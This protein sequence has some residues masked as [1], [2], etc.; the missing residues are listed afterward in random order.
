MKKQ[1][2]SFGLM[3]LS[4]VAMA[5][6]PTNGL[7]AYFPLDGNG[8]AASPSTITP[9]AFSAVGA[10]DRNGEANKCLQFVSASDHKVDYSLDDNTD[11]QLSDDFTFAFW[12]KTSPELLAEAMMVT[13]GDK[14]G[15]RYFISG[16]GAV[17][18]RFLHLSGFMSAGTVP[19]PMTTWHHYM[20]VRSGSTCSV[21]RNN[22]FT[23]STPINPVAYD[24]GEVLRLGQNA[25]LGALSKLDG[26]LDDLFIYDRALDAE[27]R[28]QVYAFNTC[29]AITSVPSATTDEPVC[30]G[31][32]M[33]F[34]LSAPHA[35]EYSVIPLNGWT[36][37][38]VNGDILTITPPLEPVNEWPYHAFTVGSSNLCSTGPT[39]EIAR[40][41]TVAPEPFTVTGPTLRCA[42]STGNY[43][44]TGTTFATTTFEFPES[45]THLGGGPSNYA[46]GESGYVTIHRTNECFTTSASL[47]VE[48][49]QSVPAAPVL[50][51]GSLSPCK[52]VPEFYAFETDPTATE[53]N[54][55]MSS[56]SFWGAEIDTDTSFYLIPQATLGPHDLYIVSGN[57]CG[58][59]ETATYQVSTNIYNGLDGFAWFEVI[60]GVLVADGYVGTITNQ[61]MLNGQPI[62][63][64]NGTTYT[65]TE[66]GYYNLEVRFTNYS[67]EPILAEEVYI[68][69][70]VVGISGTDGSGVSLFPNPATSSV[71]LDGL[72]AGTTITMMDAMGRNVMSQA[73][74]G[75]RMEVSVAGLSTGIYMVQV[76]EG[77]AVRTARLVVN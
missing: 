29:V 54:W 12:S 31:V 34:T 77:N 73:V 60:D 25:T 64:A 16:S 10:V 3:L 19:N 71:T 37:A 1:F 15:L 35:T 6:Y 30:A 67:C 46:A 47:Y 2:L 26:Y 61:W 17:S 33:T 22:N 53:H 62:E 28:A 14:I 48:V 38:S 20:V 7:V 75:G 32:P 65:P 52:D 23:A 70:G 58:A 21:Y 5:Q 41:V 8:D 51:V 9:S 66:S 59:S 76:Q 43:Q 57:I 11:L 18:I 42:G 50:T 4:G 49:V 72:T 69:L 74:S 39:T 36:D 56:G 63:G 27:E 68:D 40:T 44:A 45:W 24:A 13:F 55:W